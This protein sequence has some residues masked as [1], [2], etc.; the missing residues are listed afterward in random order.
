[1]SSSD[2]HTTHQFCSFLHFLWYLLLKWGLSVVW[3]LCWICSIV[4]NLIIPNTHGEN[5]KMRIRP[6][7]K[8]GFVSE[9]YNSKCKPNHWRFNTNEGIS[10]SLLQGKFNGISLW[11]LLFSSNHQSGKVDFTIFYK[12][13]SLWSNDHLS[14]FDTFFSSVCCFQSPVGLTVSP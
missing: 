6:W 5:K 2:L 14:T 12:S 8:S 3:F 4:S 1:M 11:N 13:S 9:L 7:A 10:V